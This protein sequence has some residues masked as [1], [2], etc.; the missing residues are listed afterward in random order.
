MFKVGFGFDVHRFSE[1]RKLILGGVEIPFEKGLLGHSDADVLIHAIID[2][3]LGAMGEND[4]GRLFP[5]TDMKYK[6][7][8]SIVLLKE[9]SK[10]LKNK[11]MS[12]I[13]IDTT[14]VAQKPKISPYTD[15]MK[16]NIAKALNIEKTQVNIKGKTTEGLGFEG[17]EE[18][19]SAYAIVLLHE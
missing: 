16:T 8:S 3:I 7:I 12:I 6:D 9:V 19:V 17:R 13:N 4:I 1:D 5:D 15:E 18:G 11:G 2:A 14:I 10:L